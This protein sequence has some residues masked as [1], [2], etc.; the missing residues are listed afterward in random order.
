[1][2]ECLS[3]GLLF[4]VSG[5]SLSISSFKTRISIGLWLLMLVVIQ[6]GYL[7]LVLAKL[8]APTKEPPIDTMEDLIDAIG[9]RGFKWIAYE[10]QPIYECMLLL[11]NIKHSD[12][13][14]WFNH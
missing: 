11:E 3:Q 13:Y 12:R 1:M 5:T 2:V 4:V 7:S 8:Q 9:N 14:E 6:Q 10:S